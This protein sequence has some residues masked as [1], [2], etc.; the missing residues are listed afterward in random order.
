MPVNIS[1]ATLLFNGVFSYINETQDINESVKYVASSSREP[2]TF[3]LGPPK[4]YYSWESDFFNDMRPQWMLIKLRRYILKINSYSLLSTQTRPGH[5]NHLISWDFL[6]STDG[7]EWK[8]IDSHRNS[9]D[10]NSSLAQKNFNCAEGYFK[11]FKV[12]QTDRGCTGEYGFG[13]RQIELFG[14]LY[15]DI[16]ACRCTFRCKANLINYIFFISVYIS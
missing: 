12:L 8:A 6:G 15:D 1:D 7:R 4:G 16:R 11:Y 13:I 5:K 2:V 9:A 14:I 3:V 10:L